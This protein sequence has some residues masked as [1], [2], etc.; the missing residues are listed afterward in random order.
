M[1][2]R[3]L[4]A[5]KTLGVAFLVLLLLAVYLTYAIFT[6]KFTDY[7]TVTLQTTSIGLQLPKRADVKVRG[8]IVGEVLDFTPTADGVSLKLG[9]YPDK[10][11]EVP[12]NVTGSIV[13]KTLFGEKYVDLVVPSDPQGSLQAGAVIERTALPVEVEKVLSD[14]LPLLR[15]VQPE[16][17][18]MTLSAIA[19][20]LDGR[21]EQLGETIET[22]DSYLKRFNPQLPQLVEDLRKTAQVSDIYSDILPEVA[23]ILDDTVVTTGTLEDRSAEVTRLYD[24]VASLADTARIFLTDNEE[25]LVRAGEL[26]TAQLRV[27]SRYSTIFPCLTE[28]LVKVGKLQAEAFRDFKL[29]IVLET[30]PRQPRAYTPADKPRI[31]E[32]RGPSCVNLPNPPWSQ[33]N[34]VKRQPNFD[35]G[36]DSPTGKGTER[37]APQ[38]GVAVPS[39]AGY[40]NS[41]EEFDLY[42]SLIAP[43]LGIT[44]EQ[45]GDLGPLLLGPMARGAE[46]TLR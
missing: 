44:P 6:K 29:H 21:G 8:V 38:Y 22:L 10:I 20:A 2:N 36:V 12:G 26:S 30:L 11:G 46:V 39:G 35:D 5:T 32:N 23:S 33:S 3:I 43:T 25:A 14:L 24:D 41:P 15:A 13:P 16:K 7:D 45:V 4:G 9:M 1:L 34:P 37:V 27:F 17:L 40:A 28:G 18:N 19:T 31:G 42:R